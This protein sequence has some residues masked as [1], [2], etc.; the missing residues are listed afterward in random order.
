MIRRE[1]SNWISSQHYL[2]SGTCSSMKEQGI[3]DLPLDASW[4]TMTK[5]ET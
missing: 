2:L 1:S 4:D 5:F 3:A